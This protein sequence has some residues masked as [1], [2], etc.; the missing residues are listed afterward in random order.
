V[1][2]AINNNILMSKMDNHT[3]QFVNTL[4]DGSY[5]LP[6]YLTLFKDHI[7]IMHYDLNILNDI[8]QFLNIETSYLYVNVETNIQEIRIISFGELLNLMGTENVHNDGEF[9]CKYHEESLLTHSVLAMLKCMEIMPLHIS[10]KQKTQI[11]ITALFHDIGK[12]RCVRKFKK[13]VNSVTAFPFHGECG[14]GIMLQLYNDTVSDYFDTKSWEIMCRTI[15]THMCGYHSKD[16]TD[17][18]TKYKMDLL[19]F[20]IDEV[21]ESLYWLSYGDSYGKIS[22]VVENI[23][24]MELREQFK[25]SVESPFDMIKFNKE[26]NIKGCI[27][28]LYGQS[29]SGKSVITKHIIKHLCSF[30]IEKTSIICIERDLIMCNVT[31]QFLTPNVEMYIE[32]PRG[33]IYSELYKSYKENNLSSI[34]N[35]QIFNLIKYNCHKIIIVDSVINYY[36]SANQIYPD[37]CKNMF[38]IAIHVIRGSKINETD[39]DRM[40]CSEEKQLELFGNRDVMSW[41]PENCKNLNAMTSISTNSYVRSC[42]IQPN[43]CFQYTWNDFECLGI[44]HINRMLRYL[45]VS[46]TYN[47]DA[48]EFLNDFETIDSSMTFLRE[49]R[50]MTNH[51]HIFRDTQ[52]EKECLFVNY[53][54]HNKDMSKQWMRQTRGSVFIKIDGK[55]QCIKKLLERGMEYATPCHKVNNVDINEN[56]NNLHDINQQNMIEKFDNGSSI[57]ACLSFKNDGSLLGITLY[58]K[59][60]IVLCDIMRQGLVNCPIAKL[61]MEKAESYDFIPVLCS[62]GTLTV[63]PDMLDY[64]VTCIGCGMMNIE[65]NDM[66]KMAKTMEP[67]QVLEMYVIDRLLEQL[68]IFW[69][70]TGELMKQ[71]MCLSFECV[72]KHRTSAWNKVHTELAVSYEQCTSKFLGCTFNIGE[73]TGVYRAHFQLSNMIEKAGFMEPLYWL[74]KDTPTINNMISDIDNIVKGE[75]T[76]EE[77]Y[78][79]YP[80]S[81]TGSNFNEIMDYEGFVIYSF[82]D[83][84]RLEFD[85]HESYCNLDY[86]KGK[87]VLYYKCHKLNADNVALLSSLPKAAEKCLPMIKSVKVFYNNLDKNL[88]QIMTK[89]MELISDCIDTI[90]PLYHEQIN[91]KLISSF[92]KKTEIN[93]QCTMVINAFTGFNKYYYDI[94][95]SIIS[96]P[97]NDLTK[98]ILKKIIMYIQPWTNNKKLL[99]NLLCEETIMSNLFNLINKNH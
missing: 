78:H 82:I 27:I 33:E 84:P 10:P 16:Y 26:N 51:P 21:K 47:P 59:S 9:K 93:I 76:I 72:S 62:S 64:Y 3:Q 8:H 12:V 94:F 67:I 73:T 50:F 91:E 68:N 56:T 43:M 48:C 39:C 88:D 17:K 28:K 99:H 57:S 23:D 18:D 42:N 35:K 98:P 74:M 60:N 11:A 36:Q 19:R 31:Q 1:Y 85:G 2:D 7:T 49:N 44:F 87:T 71:T 34:V 75:I 92:D 25:E 6:N 77:Y 37:E 97:N 90:H 96:I 41:M 46:Y 70:C 69:N 5:D 79:H 63:S 22:K 55:I 45:S 58:P 83:G 61:I 53:L 29:G 20:E 81:N 80:Y 95:N 89:V 65:Y 40:M 52:Y 86:G 66:L 54:Q 30:G 24:I 15:A 14:S 38:K 32:K 13:K 4:I